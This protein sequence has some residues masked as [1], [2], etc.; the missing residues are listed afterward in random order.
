LPPSL[1][2]SALAIQAGIAD[3]EPGLARN[4][5]RLF[6]KQEPRENAACG[7][8]CYRTARVRVADGLPCHVSSVV[9][10][11]TSSA[12]RSAL[13][14]RDGTHCHPCRPTAYLLLLVVVPIEDLLQIPE[15]LIVAVKW[16]DQL[17]DLIRRSPC[18]GVDDPLPVGR[19]IEPFEDLGQSFH[20]LIELAW[21]GALHVFQEF[22]PT[23]ECSKLLR[24]NHRPR[25]TFLVPDCC[26][27]ARSATRH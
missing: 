15:N 17:L 14:S 1:A 21:S 23:R 6:A 13:A 3:R 18:P 12:L 9:R 19:S 27:S 10:I 5:Q 11:A 4:A 16:E 24:R 25:L 2:P 7:I 26:V 20:K 8:S 22:V